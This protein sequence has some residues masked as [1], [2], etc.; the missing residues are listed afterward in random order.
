MR[1]E[2]NFYTSEELNRKVV[3]VYNYDGAY[4]WKDTFSAAEFNNLRFM[5]C[6]HRL[7]QQDKY[8]F[9]YWIKPEDT[10]VYV[11]WRTYYRTIKPFAKGSVFELFD[12]LTGNTGFQPL[13]D[14]DS[15][16]YPWLP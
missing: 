14:T 1:L 2:P 5:D 10:H 15:I 4:T 6:L 8:E 9:N 7:E 3:L 12:T 16:R 11:T 13:G